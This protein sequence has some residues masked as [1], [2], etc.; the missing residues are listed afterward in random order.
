MGA[1]R[2]AYVG[3]LALAVGLS[4]GTLASA[5]ESGA[6]GDGV[7][8]M[9]VKTIA[10]GL[11]QAWSIDFL[12]DGTGIFTQKDAKTVSTIT[13]DGKVTKVGDIPGVSVTKEAGLL[14]IAVSPSY[15][16]DKTLFLYY[17]TGSDNR[18]ATWQ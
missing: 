18:I 8:A 3:V 1:R 6:K 13:K 4:S 15:T 5:A 2:S 9:A 12:P 17:T 7:G 11:K 10:S 16:A 14:G